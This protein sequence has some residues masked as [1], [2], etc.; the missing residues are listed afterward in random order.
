MKSLGR[1]KFFSRREVRK[2]FEDAP[3][4]AFKEEI[5]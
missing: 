4:H 2:T 3:E 1:M 5:L